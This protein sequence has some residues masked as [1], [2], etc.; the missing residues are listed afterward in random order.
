MLAGNN[1]IDLKSLWVESLEGVAIFA[2]PPRPIAH[3]LIDRLVHQ[4]RRA[5]QM[6]V[7]QGYAC[8]R[9]NKRDEVIYVDIAVEFFFL[10]GA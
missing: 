3:E 1:M 10:C 2:Q 8:L 6:S 5:W 7:F 4:S 9:L